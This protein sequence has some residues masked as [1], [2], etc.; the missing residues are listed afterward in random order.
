MRLEILVGAGPLDL[1]LL[2]RLREGPL[3]IRLSDEARQRI[4]HSHALLEGLIEQDRLVY[5]VNTGFGPLSGQRIDPGGLAELQRR[6]VL[7]NA[8]GVGR[9]LPENIVRRIMLLKIATLAAGA[10]GVSEAFADALLAM[11]D[12]DMVP[13][14]PEK[15]SVGASGDLAPLAHIGVALIGE[16]E[17][18]H[19]G[20]RKPAAHAF[21]EEGLAPYSLGPKEG[22]AVVNGTQASTALAI[23]A[24]FELEEVFATGLVCGALSIEAGSGTGAAFDPRIQALRGQD[25]QQ[26]VGAVL[27]GLLRDSPLQADRPVRR[28]QDPYCLRCQPQVMGAVLDQLRH[29]AAILMKE[30]NGVSDNPLIDA[31]TGE[32]LYGGNFHAQP[33]GLVADAMALGFAE[34]GSMSERRTAFLVDTTMSGLPPFL[35]AEPGLNSGFMVAQVTAAA[36]ASEN[37]AIAHPGSIDSIP[38]AANQEDYVSMATYAARRLLPMAE[39]VRAILAIELLAAAQ[40]LEL[41]RPARSS[42]RLEDVVGGLRA[43]VPVWGCDRFFSPDIDAALDLIRDGLCLD[44]IDR[45]FLP[46]FE[47]SATPR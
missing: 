34:I 19:R 7:S 24:L 23:E 33:I 13:V 25:G 35:A 2:R 21:Q 40:G 44:R 46:S 3:R 12:A 10:S 37:K 26:T 8:A 31:G 27:S 43:R 5:G 16:G 36:L 15:G 45:D 18:F 32:V 4:R 41:R 6:V 39:N 1:P 29:A 30:I 38:T 14:V 42:D 9:P 22:L 47:R 11:L 20:E 28:V 17:V